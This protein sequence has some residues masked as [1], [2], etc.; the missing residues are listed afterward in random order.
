M[1]FATHKL[2]LSYHFI[3][4]VRRFAIESRQ[5]AGKPL[6]QNDLTYLAKFLKASFNEQPPVPRSQPFALDVNIVLEYFLK[7]GPNK[8]LPCITLAGKNHFV[9]YAE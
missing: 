8:F 7:L 5:L 6:T 9:D 3:K 1:H 4:T 2:K